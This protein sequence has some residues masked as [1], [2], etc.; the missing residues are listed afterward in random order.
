MSDN[1]RGLP[2]RT[3][4]DPDLKVQVK[5]VDFTTPSQ[6]QVVD[7][8]GNAHVELHGNDNAG[9]DKVVALSEE[10]RVNGNGDYDVA[11]NTKP[12]S[13]APIMHDRKNTA[14]TPTEADQNLRPT[15]VTYDNGV[16]TTVVAQDMAMHDENGV[17]YSKS[18]P[19]SVAIEE[20]K[21]IEIHDYLESIDVISNGGTAVHTYTVVSGKTFLLE[22]VLC[23]GSLAHSMT[24]EI[25]D[26]GATEIF[27]PKAKRF[28]SEDNG[29][30]DVEFKKTL[31][32][33]GTA[34]GTTVKVTVQN[35]DS[36]ANVSI[37]TTIVGLLHNT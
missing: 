26:G 35:R 28:A 13:S 3:Q 2:I 11:L 25:G 19:L 27:A 8:D 21:G 14:Q 18:N 15:G 1:K 10:G 20:S 24:L 37:Y 36:H 30:A 12:S 32:V 7:V 17:P 4:E 29:N 34:N 16:D 33:I 31:K 23:D 9:T 22:Q 5:N 6:G